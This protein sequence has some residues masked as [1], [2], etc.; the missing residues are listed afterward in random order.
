MTKIIWLFLIFF[1]LLLLKVP[2]SFSL[3]CAS[4]I[5]MKIANVSVLAVVQ[6]SIAG[7][8]SFTLLSV[9]FF[10]LAGNLM[11]N[12]GVTE[13]ITRGTAEDRGLAECL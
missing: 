10:V 1:I 6:R 13:K 11:N 2:V 9:G 5:Y 12:G 8:T 3:L 7:D 4:V